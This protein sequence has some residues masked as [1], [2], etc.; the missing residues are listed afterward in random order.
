[1]FTLFQNLTAPEP[2]KTTKKTH[3]RRFGMIPVEPC[4]VSS[5]QTLSEVSCSGELSHRGLELVNY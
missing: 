2:Q 4:R 3:K 5:M 1:M